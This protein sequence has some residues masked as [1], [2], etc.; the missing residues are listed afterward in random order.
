MSNAS[1]PKRIKVSKRVYEFGEWTIKD[2]L[3]NVQKFINELVDQYGPTAT[4]QRSYEEYD[5][6]IS[7][8]VFVD[9]EENDVEYAKRCEWLEQQAARERQQYLALKEKYGE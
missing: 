5:D 9:R 1:K 3:G 4:I 2:S 6:S 8:G 7:Y